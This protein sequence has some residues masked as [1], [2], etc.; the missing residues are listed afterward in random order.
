MRSRS[1]IPQFKNPCYP[2][3][4]IFD[5]KLSQ[6]SA[7]LLEQAVA[8]N[9]LRLVIY[10]PENWVLEHIPPPDPA[11]KL[12]FNPQKDSAEFRGQLRYMIRVATLRH[13][14]TIRHLH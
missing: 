10:S 9:R 7:D 8:L 3:K 14:E 6:E 12:Q 1:A 5:H 2:P 4:M 13:A 11:G